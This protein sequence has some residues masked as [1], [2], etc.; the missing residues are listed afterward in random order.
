MKIVSNLK[1]ISFFFFLFVVLLNSVTL[2]KVKTIQIDYR[3]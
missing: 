3:K 2:V 1:F